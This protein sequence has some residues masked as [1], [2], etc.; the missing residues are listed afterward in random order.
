MKSE[1][2][3]ATSSNQAL[4]KVG[5]NPLF[6]DANLFAG[7]RYDELADRF[8]RATQ[9]RGVSSTK[10]KHPNDGTAATPE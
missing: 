2:P 6:D 3:N 1:H 10:Q 4:V 9:R 5:N 8:L 7:E